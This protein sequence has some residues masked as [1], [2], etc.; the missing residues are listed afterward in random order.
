VRSGMRNVSP[1]TVPSLLRSWRSSW[2][3]HW[4][5]C[6]HSDILTQIVSCLVGLGTISLW[7]RGPKLGPRWPSG[8]GRLGRRS[9]ALGRVADEGRAQSHH[10]RHRLTTDR[11]CCNRFHG[12]AA[13]TS[14][15]KLFLPTLKVAAARAAGDHAR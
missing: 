12:Q 10:R 3:R 15:L 7:R 14:H 11:V 1:P 4:L 13:V 8:N 6:L 2:Q 5:D 9:P